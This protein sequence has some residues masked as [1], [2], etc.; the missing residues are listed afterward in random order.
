MQ[1]KPSTSHLSAFNFHAEPISDEDLLRGFE[2]TLEANGRAATT[3]RTYGDAVMMLSAF[4]R[5][6]GL[7]GLVAMDRNV[8]RHFLVSLRQK[9]HK[10]GGIHVRYRGL[11]RFFGWCVDE[12]E[13]VDNPMDYIDPPQNPDEIQPHYSEQ[14][15]ETVL[16]SIGNK[17][18]HEL[19]D[20]AAVLVLYDTG[21]RA[22]ELAGMF[23]VD[24]D[25][26]QRTV[27][28]T[29]KAGKQRYVSMGHTAAQA[30]ERYLRRRRSD[31]P[32]LW[33]ANGNKQLK[34][35]GLRMMLERRFQDADVPFRGTHGF[36]RAFA[37]NHLA[38]GG[39]LDDLVQLAGWSTYA[40]ASRYAKSNASE[41][42]VAAYKRI[43]AADRLNV[44]R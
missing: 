19:R 27:K 23:V 20:R 37:M 31:S 3:V 29:G 4:A 6:L 43:S 14:D 26:R 39:G 28:V 10:P 17:S 30:I 18:R 22:A 41:R 16:K 34:L 9:G 25:W 38:A 12:G 40:M 8:V 11:N 2:L 7:P 13:R 35:N 36:R 44:S 5:A 42:A 33:E 15:I 21:V 1:H 24:I 32:W